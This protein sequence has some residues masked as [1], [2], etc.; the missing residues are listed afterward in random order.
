MEGLEIGFRD[1]PV[2]APALVH[3]VQPE[4]G[5]VRALDAVRRMAVRAHRQLLCG[6][7][8]LRAVDAHVEHLVDAAVALGAGQ[9]DVGAVDA[10]ARIAG[11]QFVMR[12]VAV[13]AIRGDGEAALKQSLAV[14]AL[15]IML[16]DLALFAGVPQGGFLARLMALGAQRRHVARERGRG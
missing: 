4:V 2:A 6:F 14:N 13:G 10:G 1:L 11:G 5:E 15:L 3:D 7:G 12:G 16:Y 9:G 8:H